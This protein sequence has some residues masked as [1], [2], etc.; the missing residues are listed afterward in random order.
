METK[1]CIKCNNEKLLELFSLNNKSLDGFN[2]ICKEC[3][4]NYDIE[5]RKNNKLIIKEKQKKHY[6]ENHEVIDIKNRKYFIDNLD[7]VKD[8]QKSYRIENSD[9]IK[10]YQKNYRIEN[11]T[12]IGEYHTNRKKS[13]MVYRLTCN[14]RSMISDSFRRNGYSKSSKT[15]QILDCSFED[16]KLHLEVKFEPWMNWDNYGKYNGEYGYGWDIDHIIPLSSAKT[17]E[18]LIKLNHYSNLQPLCSKINRD[19]KINRKKY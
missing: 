2:S 10:T 16:F 14:Y 7:K 13:D 8:Y 19:I 11:K 18:E 17:E 1:K 3:K 12:K 15:Y 9:N 4:R 5:Y 6:S